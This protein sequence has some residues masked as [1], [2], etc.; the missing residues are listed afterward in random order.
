[1]SSKD[2]GIDDI[3]ASSLATR[4]VVNIGGVA[5]LGVRNATKSPCSILLG[6]QLLAVNLSILLDELN[7][8]A[9]SN[10]SK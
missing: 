3:G 4:A 6:D 1:M 9:V 8:A 10:R 5:R 7:L 2:T